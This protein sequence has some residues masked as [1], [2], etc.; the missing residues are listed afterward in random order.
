[1]TVTNPSLSDLLQQA[2]A[3]EVTCGYLQARGLSSVGTFALIARDHESLRKILIQP[4][5]QGFKKGDQVFELDDAD[6]PVAEA[7]LLTVWDEANQV[8]KK[9]L[10]ATGPQNLPGTPA[11]ATAP[12]SSHSTEDKPPKTLPHGVWTAAIQRY[13]SVQI[14]GIARRFPEKELLGAESILARAHFEH[15]KSKLYTPIGLGEI[16][17]HRSF[18]AVGE[19]NPLAKSRAEAKSTLTIEGDKLVQ[20]AEKHWT[21]KSV[22]SIIDAIRSLQWAWVLLDFGPELKIVEFCDWLCLRARARPH[23]LEQ[24]RLWYE[25]VAWQLATQ[26]RVG[27]SFA[28]AAEVIRADLE[29]YQ[30]TMAKEVAPT[31]KRAQKRKLEDSADDSRLQHPAKGHGK[32]RNPWR[33]SSWRPP[34][35]SSPP[36]L[37]SKA[38]SWTSWGNGKQTMPWQWSGS[39]NS[40]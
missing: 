16:M 7:V 24:F 26:M 12:S 20:E 21:P 29:L 25:Q 37:T 35:R 8:W 18:T 38:A 39:E 19:P 3:D 40:K 2:G 6:K 5:L 22:L 10:A 31:P 36:W 30:E 14:Q 11:P 33:Q 15:T 23:K 28:E 4:L 34:M 9:H 27:K 17:T 32:T 13:N 1:M